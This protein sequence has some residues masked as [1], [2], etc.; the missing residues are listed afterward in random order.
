MNRRILNVSAPL[1]ALGLLVQVRNAA[2]A[3][4]SANGFDIRIDVY[5]TN[6]MPSGLLKLRLGDAP[7]GE[8]L[9][10]DEQS[11]PVYVSPPPTN[12][13]TRS[14]VLRAALFTYGFVK[15]RGFGKGGRVVSNPDE[16]KRLAD[17]FTSNYLPRIGTG[18]FICP[19]GFSVPRLLGLKFIRRAEVHI[20]NLRA[21]EAAATAPD[22][23][24]KFAAVRRRDEEWAGRLLLGDQA[25]VENPILPDVSPS[26]LARQLRSEPRLRQDPEAA[27]GTDTNGVYVIPLQ[28]ASRLFAGALEAGV[29]YNTAERFTG[30]GGVTLTNLLQR[31][32]FDTADPYDSFTLKGRAGPQV[33]SSGGS[34]EIPFQRADAQLQSKVAADGNFDHNDRTAF[35]GPPHFTAETKS[36]SGE[37]NGSAQYDSF[38]LRD[39]TERML[40]LPLRKKTQ[41]VLSLIAGMKY[42]DY[43]VLGHGAA[44]P[45]EEGQTTKINGR[46]GASVSFDWH[47]PEQAGIGKMQLDSSLLGAVVPSALSDHFDYTMWQAALGTTIWFGWQDSRDFFLSQNARNGSLFGHAPDLELFRLGG[48]SVRGLQEGELAGQSVLSTST[49]LGYGLARLGHLLFSSTNSTPLDATYLTGFIDWGRTSQSGSIGSP[50]HEGSGAV[51]YGAAI[52]IAQSSLG[53]LSRFNIG[54]AYSPQ[55]KLHRSGMVFVSASFPF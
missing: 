9:K 54:Y 1:L 8:R 40:D 42:S 2:A 33:Q 15:E 35:P 29:S 34:W 50:W 21:D 49:E 3:A 39:K 51:A 55:S 22:Q 23:K 11:I 25:G 53:P 36:W 24:E 20:N 10:T 45:P 18:G 43:S 17:E 7:Q 47:K 38:S 14:E 46:L 12:P 6:R 48:S 37:V 30:N 28:E 41:Y 31:K 16:A 4:P 27:P 52:D 44:A 5:G 19:A 32:A 13:I 26:A